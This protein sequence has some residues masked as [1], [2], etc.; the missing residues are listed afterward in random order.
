MIIAP[1]FTGAR[2]Y[3]IKPTCFCGAGRSTSQPYALAAHW[4]RAAL[5]TG[6][7]PVFYRRKQLLVS[8]AAGQQQNIEI[9][10]RGDIHFGRQNQ[11]L[12]VLLQ[13]G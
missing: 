9:R 6:L 8:V 4:L 7:A 13:G 1:R 12:N 3:V 5:I 11:P 2:F 10:R